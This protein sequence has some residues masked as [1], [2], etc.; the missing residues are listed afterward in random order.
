[1]TYEVTEFEVVDMR[2][3]RRTQ[4]KFELSQEV[5]ETL[6]TLQKHDGLKILLDVE[7]K[8][9][10]HR[11]RIRSYRLANPDINKRFKFQVRQISDDELDLF[12]SKK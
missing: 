4:L 12:I 1:M 7:V 5:L 8:V 6:E 9:P 2:T 11:T 3:V 10:T